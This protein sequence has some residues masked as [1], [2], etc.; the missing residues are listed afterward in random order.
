MTGIVNNWLK[1]PSAEKFFQQEQNS[2]EQISKILCGQMGIQLCLNEKNDYL[3]G[4]NISSQYQVLQKY[5]TS[6]SSV[7]TDNTAVVANL[8]ELP[9]SSN[10]FAVVV[11]PQM[12][13]FSEDSYAALREIYRITA[14]GGFVVVSGINRFS[15][16]GLQAKSIP[17]KYPLLPTV[18]LGQMKVWLSLLGCDIV[19]GDL[20][21]YSAM[22]NHANYP[23]VST[24]IE[25]IGNRW[26]PMTAGGYW[27]VAKKRLFGQATRRSA[28]LKHMKAGKIAGQVA[29]K[30]SFKR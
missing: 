13:L 19:A 15:L 14:S 11:V 9:F 29:N 26:L 6:S 3:A 4:I 27:L 2:F 8:E 1:S 17:H 22:S 12:N 20:F 25:K 10:Q 18:S 5:Y 28:K 21:H 7:K 16:M 24:K 23:N 30:L